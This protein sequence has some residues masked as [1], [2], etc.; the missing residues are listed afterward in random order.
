VQAPLFLVFS[1]T[2]HAQVCASLLCSVFGWTPQ[3]EITN[4][5]WVM[6]GVAIGLLTEYATGVDFVNQIGLM[7]SYLVSAPLSPAGSQVLNDNPAC[8]IQHC[9]LVTPAL[10]CSPAAHVRRASQTLS[11]ADSC[12]QQPG[13]QPSLYWVGCQHGLLCNSRG[14]SSTACR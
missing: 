1:D 13:W 4:G 2:E 5:R 10:A 12:Q 7:L 9:W 11:E 8:V 6:M 3:N 14:R